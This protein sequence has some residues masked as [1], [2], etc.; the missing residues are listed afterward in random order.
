M[1]FIY[2][3]LILQIFQIFI[4]PDT[5][6]VSDE[7]KFCCKRKAISNFYNNNDKEMSLDTPI[8]RND[9]PISCDVESKKSF[10]LD[11][12]NYNTSLVSIII[13][14]SIPHERIFN[15]IYF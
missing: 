3:K 5:N 8:S 9:I 14:L 10:S 6:E 7:K 15:C 13:L 12:S 1:N 4:G 11:Y 2:I